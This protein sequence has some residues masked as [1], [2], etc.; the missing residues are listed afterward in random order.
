MAGKIRLEN[1]T[2]DF[3]GFES[4]DGTADVIWKL[5]DA[6]GSDG[7]VLT[8]DGAKVLSWN[9]IPDATSTVSGLL[10]SYREG[11]GTESSTQNGVTFTYNWV[12]VANI[13]CMRIAF[14][15]SFTG[16]QNVFA[17]QLQG[18]GSD[19]APAVS[20]ALP[21]T[22]AFAG[23]EETAYISVFENGGYVRIDLRR[24]ANTNFPNSVI[25]GGNTMGGVGFTY[26]LI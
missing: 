19:I 1:A 25:T 26:V 24:N 12:K 6:D 17:Y 3:S 14:S 2:G 10:P 20:Q 15:G 11:T 9:P 18:G 13:V 22:I 16:T 8:T 5:P 21:V 23:V 7:E 4:G